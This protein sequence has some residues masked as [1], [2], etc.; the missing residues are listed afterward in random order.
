MMESKGKYVTIPRC[1]QC[2]AALPPVRSGSRVNPKRLYCSSR[3]RQA[4][5]RAR[6]REPEHV[7]R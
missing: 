7:D 5:Y 4:A 1:R 3:C 2:G 6:Q